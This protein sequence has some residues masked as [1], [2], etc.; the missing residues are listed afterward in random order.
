MLMGGRL[1]YTSGE[2][3][4]VAYVKSSVNNGFMGRRI[5]LKLL[6]KDFK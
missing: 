4:N 3:N 2:Y 5:K 6:T 1:F